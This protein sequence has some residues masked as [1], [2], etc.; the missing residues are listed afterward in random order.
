MKATADTTK[1]A[2]TIRHRSR[3]IRWGV[4]TGNLA[5]ALGLITWGALLVDGASTITPGAF[6][7]NSLAYA[8]LGLVGLCVLVVAGLW[9]SWLSKVRAGDLSK[10]PGLVVLAVAW[11]PTVELILREDLR[12][13]SSGL[14]GAVISLQIP[15]AVLAVGLLASYPCPRA[16]R[17]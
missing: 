9:L 2:A 14:A 5:A 11:I 13:S 3:R 1:N 17:T 7:L 15:L 4:V 12:V 6:G 8:L 10:R 16:A